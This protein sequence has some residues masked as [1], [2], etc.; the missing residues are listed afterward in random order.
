MKS[1]PGPLQMPLIGNADSAQYQTEL[2][3]THLAA[4]RT[5][6]IGSIGQAQP[7]SGRLFRWRTRPI[8]RINC[9]GCYILVHYRNILSQ[10]MGCREACPGIRGKGRCRG[11]A[12]GR[13]FVWGDC[14]WKFLLQSEDHLKAGHHSARISRWLIRRSEGR[15]VA[16][17]SILALVRISKITNCRA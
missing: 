7:F 4:R 14:Q 1:P 5:E 9:I 6:F 2:L 16:G 10:K 17:I 11:K 15:R 12:G 13:N 8:D 3:A